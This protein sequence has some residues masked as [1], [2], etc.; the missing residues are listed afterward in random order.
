M[1]IESTEKLLTSLG[2]LGLTFVLVITLGYVVRLIPAI[3]NRFIPAI[4]PLLGGILMPL[5]A[6]SGFVGES[7]KNPIVVLVIYGFIV[8]VVAWAAHAL[9]I[10]RIEDFIRSKIPSVDRALGGEKQESKKEE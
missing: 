5:L 7:W 8:G 10:S 1:N 4:A 3:N 2:P 6:P 9:I